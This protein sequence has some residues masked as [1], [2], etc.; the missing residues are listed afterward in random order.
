MRALIR[1][2]RLGL[3]MLAMNPGS[4]LLIVGLLSLGLGATTVLFSLYDAAF[5]R[6]LGVRHPE[7][8][9]RMVQYLPK[10]GTHSDFPYPYYE[11]LHD[12][13]T[14]LAATFGDTGKYMHFALT[15]PEPA[16]LITLH[17]ETPEF[18]EALGVGALYGRVLLPSDANE[19]PGMPPAVLSYGF[20]RRRFAGDPSVVNRRTVLVNGHR[21]VIVGVMP[22]D[23]NGFTVDTTPDLRIPLRALLPLANFT[24]D[25]IYLDLAGR[26]KPGFTRLQ[27]EEECRALWQATMKDYLQN[28]WKLPPQAVSRELSDG[29]WLDPLERGISVLRDRYG[30]I[31][32]ML[33]ASAGLLVLIICT[34][35][36]GLL[37]A[38]AAARQHEIAVRLA[39]GA[40]R[41]RLIRQVLAES[42]LLAAPGATGGLLIALAAM[43]LAVRS[44]PPIRDL[45]SSLVQLSVDVGIKWR[46]FLFLLGL[47]LLTMLLFSLSPAIA[48]SRSNLDSLLRTVRSSRGWRG[49]QAL[50]TVQI[51]L[52]TFLLAIASLFVS[53]FQ[54]LRRTDPGFDRD[55]IATFTGGLSTPT[56]ASAFP[57]TLTERVR[58]LPGVVSVAIAARGVMRDRGLG[59]TVAPA[60]QE[61]TRA[62]FLNTSLNNV[63]PEYFD[64]MG[65]H[66][67]AGRGFIPEDLP[68]P[69]RSGPVVAVVN[70]AFA[71]RFF[72]NTSPVGK[73]FGSGAEG[74]AKEQYE[75]IG[76]V[77]DAKYRSLREAI[78]PTFYTPGS[79]FDQFVLSVR[80]RIRPEAIIEPVRK[81]LASI[82]PTLSFLEVHTLAEEVDNSIAS[83]RLTAALASMFGGIAALLVGAGIYGLLAYVVTE[84]R[85]EIGIRMALGAQ[86]AHIGKLIAGQTLAMTAAGVAM[87]LAGALMAGPGIRPLLYGIS[88]QDP[89]SLAAAMMFVALT[90]V[91]A[92]ILP[93]VRATRVDP[94]VALRYE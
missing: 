62:D 66:I 81:V 25:K 31:L 38:R 23:F 1:D 50:I 3:R 32:S 4:A 69:K 43:P 9:V 63:S 10:V 36:G 60:G 30:K 68:G 16:E 28:V 2:I 83:E 89:K 49:R 80:T 11:A 87:G 70:Q 41:F 5:F 14:T 48:V 17:A 26:L 55:H 18:F 75:I 82:D 22:R 56:G 34:N 27:A 77:S 15:D 93:T 44:L 79:I 84:R 45:S 21:F 65:M 24:L 39:V 6:R 72:P 57:R 58:E 52:C 92:T 54:Q 33:M 8:L 51:A 74:L 67:L 37:L 91:V 59:T 40:T 64:T 7:Q 46:V 13:V 35:V 90:A 19:S 94:M 85:H 47:S 29:M 86:P 53:T 12:H 73:R 78:I 20:W 71:E 42:F 88:P 76:V 61:I